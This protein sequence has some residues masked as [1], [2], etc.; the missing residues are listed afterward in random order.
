MSGYDTAGANESITD[1]HV[2]GRSVRLNAE[3][4]GNDLPLGSFSP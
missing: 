2:N 4:P 1:G 3:Q